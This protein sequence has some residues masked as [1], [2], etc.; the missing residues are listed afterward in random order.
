MAEKEQNHAIKYI[1]K[2][3]ILIQIDKLQ[4]VNLYID[5]WKK[6]IE[7]KDPD[8][9]CSEFQIN[10]IRNKATYL[11][12]VYYMSLVHYNDVCDLSET[13]E[14]SLDK[15]NDVHLIDFLPEEKNVDQ[16]F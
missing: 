12:M 3:H 9:L 8:Q 1:V 10:K 11:A 2:N 14:M 13:I 4:E 7:D 16:I 6:I 5:G 15:V